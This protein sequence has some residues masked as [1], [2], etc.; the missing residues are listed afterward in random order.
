MRAA[1]GRELRLRSLAE[2]KLGSQSVKGAFLPNVKDEPRPQPARLVRHSDLESGV[3][4]EM[5][6][7]AR[8]VTAVVVGSGALL[9]DWTSEDPH[10]TAT[11]LCNLKAI[12]IF[13]RF[14]TEARI[15]AQP[16]NQANSFSSIF[17]VQLSSGARVS[18]F[19]RI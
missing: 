10:R 15:L 19:N 14:T 18:H 6:S 2:G 7:I 16:P 13:D 4:F 17:K 12:T 9:G 5:D 3:S 11:S 1:S 8:G